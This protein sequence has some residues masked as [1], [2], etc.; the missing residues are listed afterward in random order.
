MCLIRNRPPALRV[1]VLLS[2]AVLGCVPA[3][4]PAGIGRDRM[5]MNQISRAELEPQLGRLG[6]AFDIIRALRP[7]MLDSRD[8]AVRGQSRSSVWQASSGI[9]VYLDGIAYEGF[10]SLATIPAATVQE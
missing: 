8:V 3:S 6:T 2:L 1:G 10:G 7:N 5:D 4:G 9:K